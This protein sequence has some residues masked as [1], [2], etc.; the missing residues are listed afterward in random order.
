MLRLT[1]KISSS[2]WIILTI[3]ATTNDMHAHHRL[4]ATHIHLF[5]LNGIVNMDWFLLLKTFSSW[6]SQGKEFST[7]AL[8]RAFRLIISDYTTSSNRCPISYSTH[9]VYLPINQTVWIQ[10]SN[11]RGLL[12]LESGRPSSSSIRLFTLIRNRSETLIENIHTYTYIL[13]QSTRSWLISS[14]WVDINRHHYA[15]VSEIL[16]V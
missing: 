1:G 12:C 2:L 5:E 8:E 6:S 15:Q 9:R 7:Q 16:V 4:I 13:T 11:T 10:M 14:S 3:P